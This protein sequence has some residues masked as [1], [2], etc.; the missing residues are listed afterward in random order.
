MSWL[1]PSVHAPTD[2]RVVTNRRQR[3]IEESSHRHDANQVRQ[4]LEVV[5]VAAVEVQAVGVCG[6]GDE[7][8]RE[9]AAR[10]SASADH[11]R[12]DQALTATCSAVKW[13]WLE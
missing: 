10:L 2:K 7:Q 4:A 5:R 13:N 3:Q 1:W 8:I 9:A 11:G 12:N 6:R